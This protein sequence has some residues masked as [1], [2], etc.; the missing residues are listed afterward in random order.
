MH[1]PSIRPGEFWDAV[2]GLVTAKVEPVIGRDERVRG[3]VIDYL[4]DLEALARRH[5]SSRETV[6][7]IASGRRLL[8]DRSEVGPQDGPF[9]QS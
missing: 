2:A 8:G 7:I 9:A 6:Q 1:E 3:P 5:C 4:R